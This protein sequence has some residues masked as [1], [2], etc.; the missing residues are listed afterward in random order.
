M[1]GTR[2]SPLHRLA[3]VAFLLAWLAVAPPV[4]VAASCFV[5]STTDA[6]H[7]IATLG[8][9]DC[10]AL[11]GAHTLRAAFDELNSEPPGSSMVVTFAPGLGVILLG[12]PLVL[13][14]DSTM[15]ITG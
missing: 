6:G 12:S 11:G 4:A 2:L 9:G 7:N 3:A 8:N 5:N 1:P 13:S 14:Q 15:S 10:D